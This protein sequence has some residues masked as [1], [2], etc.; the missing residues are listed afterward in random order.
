[1]LF[2]GDPGRTGVEGELKRLLNDNGDAETGRVA[3]GTMVEAGVVEG[4]VIALPVCPN[5]KVDLVPLKEVP[6]R[7]RV[8]EAPELVSCKPPNKLPVELLGPMLADVTVV[9]VMVEVIGASMDFPRRG[10]LLKLNSEV[11]VD[12]LA[13]CM[14]D[15]FMDEVLPE[16]FVLSSAWPTLRPEKLPSV[17]PVNE[18]GNR[19]S[20]N[21]GES[22][23]GLLD[24]V[25]VTGVMGLLDGNA[26]PE[27]LKAAPVVLAVCKIPELNENV[28]YRFGSL[29]V[30]VVTCETVKLEGGADVIA[31]KLKPVPDEENENGLLNCPAVDEV[32]VIIVSILVAPGPEILS[33]DDSWPDVT[34]A[35]ICVGPG[36]DCVLMEFMR[37]P[38]LG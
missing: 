17:S 19:C 7:F 32:E 23:S 8:P 18:F 14:L 1:M 38:C 27:E 31:P 4:R 9:V 26:S 6:P 28:S 15:K 33:P 30:A 36:G 12:V 35:G 21:F 20:P 13:G 10:A 22:A 24:V 2:P 29:V 25:E 3:G 34:S 11:R 16:A 37:D 5:E